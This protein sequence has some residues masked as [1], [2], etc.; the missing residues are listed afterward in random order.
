MNQDELAAGRAVISRLAEQ[1]VLRT[2]TTTTRFVALGSQTERDFGLYE[3]V[4][5]ASTGGVGAHYHRNFTE[6]FYVLEG[7]LG[8]L[9]GRDWVTV[10]AGDLVYVPRESVHGFRNTTDSQARFLILFTP[11]IPREE[12]FT[13]NAARRAAGIELTEA[14][15]D[16]FAAEHDQYNVR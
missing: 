2:A 15:Q 10:G 5:A 8:V 7:E 11:G 12:Y 1:H 6:T 4:L 9:N 13:A 3:Y 14:E 16:A